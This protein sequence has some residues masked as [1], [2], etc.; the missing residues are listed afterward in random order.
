MPIFF[1]LTRYKIQETLFNVGLHNI[2]S[3]DLLSD[4]GQNVLLLLYYFPRLPVTP[5][6][7]RLPKPGERIMSMAGSPLANVP[8]TSKPGADEWN[9]PLKGDK[10]SFQIVFS[11]P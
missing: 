6:L 7:F 2:S 5:A 9:I 3:I 10:V 4:Y 8:K 11:R 1:L